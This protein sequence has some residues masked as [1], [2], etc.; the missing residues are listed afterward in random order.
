MIAV[1]TQ[2]DLAQGPFVVRGHRL[3]ERVCLS[4]T[5]PATATTTTPA[6]AA[7]PPLVRVH[8]SCLFGEAMHAL[9]CDCRQQLAGALRLVA[10]AGHGA[11][12][13]L[14]QEGRGVGI[15]E[16]IAAM[17]VQR[18][19]GVD[20]YEAF[21]RLGHRSDERCYDLAV[22]ALRDLGLAG[23]PIRLISNNPAKRRALEAAGIEVAAMVPLGYA[24]PERARP[25][26]LS[27]RDH[28]L[29]DIDLDIIRF[30]ATA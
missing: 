17:E 13:Y 1:E 30:S 15:V 28:G 7:G 3:G 4:L 16:K 8:S 22:E 25:Y 12:V 18:A 6:P 5:A 10:A 14:Y 24:L 19:H 9:D 20:T 27:K 23:G 11:L 2:L 21:R 26:L 29:H